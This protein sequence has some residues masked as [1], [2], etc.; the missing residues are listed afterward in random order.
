M[1]PCPTGN[2]SEIISQ[3]KTNTIWDLLYVKSKKNTQ[4]I[5]TQTRMVVTRGWGVGQG[6]PICC[7]KVTKF[8][9]RMDNMVDHL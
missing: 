9:D 2:K 3:R 8:W 4:L 1:V 7:Y 6:A 5:V